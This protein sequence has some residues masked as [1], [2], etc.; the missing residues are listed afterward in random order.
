MEVFVNI[1]KKTECSYSGAGDLNGG[2]VSAVTTTAIL[3]CHS[4]T[5]LPGLLSLPG[6]FLKLAVKGGCVYKD[7]Q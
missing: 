6:L 2:L 3:V 5:S 4:G 1:V 7:C